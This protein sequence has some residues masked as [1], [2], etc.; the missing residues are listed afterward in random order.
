MSDKRDFGLVEPEVSMMDYGWN[1][2][3]IKIDFMTGKTFGV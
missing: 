3:N 1:E 2:D